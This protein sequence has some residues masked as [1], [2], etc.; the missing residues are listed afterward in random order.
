MHR[1]NAPAQACIGAYN[2]A[3]PISERY[4]NKDREK[5]KPSRA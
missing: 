2:N 4:A 3:P 1:E 5:D